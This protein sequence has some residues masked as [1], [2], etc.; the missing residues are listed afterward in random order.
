[1]EEYNTNTIRH[2]TNVDALFKILKSGLKFSSGRSWADKNDA[3]DIERYKKI[4][5]KDVAILCMCDGKGNMYH[6]TNLGHKNIFCKYSNI[7][8]NIAFYKDDFLEYVSSLNKFEKPRPIIYCDETETITQELSNIP[9]LKNKEYIVEKEIRLLYIGDN[10]QKEAIIP[11]IRPYIRNI[12]I[13][14]NDCNDKNFAIIKRRIEHL[15][16]QLKGHITPNKSKL[17]G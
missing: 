8:C 16:P 1:M 13:S 7:K 11:N 17:A 10:A 6:W 9:F 2:F 5:N 12:T 4:V 3:Y 15:Y 14:K